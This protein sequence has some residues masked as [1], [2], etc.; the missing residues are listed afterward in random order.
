MTQIDNTHHPA[1]EVIAVRS[2]CNWKVGL[3]LGSSMTTY[4]EVFLR[5]DE[6]AEP[7]G[8]LFPTVVGYPHG[9]QPGDVNADVIIGH[10]AVMSWDAHQMVFPNKN[11]ANDPSR[12]ALA[13][14]DF[15]SRLRVHMQNR[16]APAWGVVA[17]P[18]Q[19]T[20]EF[21][22]ELR[23]VANVLF[24]RVMIVDSA[25]LLAMAL[26]HEMGRKCSILVDLGATSTRMYLMTILSPLEGGQIILD[27]GGDWVDGQVREGLL[28][29]YPD[30]CA[31]DVTI[32]QFKEKMAFVAPRDKRCTLRLT[33][34]S[35]VRNLDVTEIVTE[36]CETLVKELNQGFKKLLT[37]CPSDMLDSFISN[38]F[39]L[40]GGAQMDGLAMR[41]E[42]DLQ[43]QGLENAMVRSLPAAQSVASIGALKWALSTDD[44]RWGIPLFTYG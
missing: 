19:A 10:E 32:T 23:A 12:R 5:D 40:G 13:L 17:K 1:N 15:A 21:L 3:D 34:G 25:Q 14:K 26:Y 36:P 11:I 42:R 28:S 4:Q 44:E 6:K 31:S 18:A 30:L 29:R 24:E 22:S 16:Q 37:R 41:V 20:P 38:V 7:R 2:E 9:H 39:L 43:D 35:T 8:L 27:K 33:L